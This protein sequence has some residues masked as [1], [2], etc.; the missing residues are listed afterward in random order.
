MSRANDLGGSATTSQYTDAVI[1]RVERKLDV[2]D[3]LG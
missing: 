2:W 3:S 1:T